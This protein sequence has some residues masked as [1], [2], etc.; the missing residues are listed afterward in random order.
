[1]NS[2]PRTPDIVNVKPVRPPVKSVRPNRQTSPAGPVKSRRHIHHFSAIINNMNKD[3]LGFNLLFVG[4]IQD[5]VA[6]KAGY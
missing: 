1:M 4:I 6:T 5:A 3:Y 2:V